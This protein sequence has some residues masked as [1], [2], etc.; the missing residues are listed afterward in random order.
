M[1]DKM[2]LELFLKYFKH[3]KRE[4]SLFELKLFEFGT[5]IKSQEPEKFDP[6]NYTYTNEL[7]V[8]YIQ[9]AWY[10]FYFSIQFPNMKKLWA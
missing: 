1:G 7:T 3:Y 5:I 4:F 8:V 2:K 6:L 9:L 10:I